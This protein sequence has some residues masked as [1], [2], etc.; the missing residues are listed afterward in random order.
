MWY[1]VPAG[2]DGLLEAPCPPDYS[3][4]QFDRWKESGSVVAGF[5]GHDHKN[6]FTAQLDGTDM[7]ACPGATYTSYHELSA[8]GIQIIELD[9]NTPETYTS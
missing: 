6:F 5:S 4:G 8:R 1:I 7:V 3:N 9:E 2:I